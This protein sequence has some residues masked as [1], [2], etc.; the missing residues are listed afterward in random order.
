MN[1]SEHILVLDTSVLEIS[2]MGRREYLIYLDKFHV[3]LKHLFIKY[4]YIIDKFIL[5]APW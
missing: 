1:V 3:C 2:N 4:I 5:K